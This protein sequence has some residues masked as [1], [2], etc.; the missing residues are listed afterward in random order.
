MNGKPSPLRI[1]VSRT[2]RTS[3]LISARYHG[4]HLVCEAHTAERHLGQDF[5]PEDG[6]RN[7]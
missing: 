5:N 7:G 6:D 2:V 3:E 4:L 1:Q